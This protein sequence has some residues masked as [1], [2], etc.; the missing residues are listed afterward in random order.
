M[1]RMDF[2]FLHCSTVCNC[3]SLDAARAK[4]DMI[5]NVRLMVLS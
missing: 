2:T 1:V 3:Q 5:L 4:F